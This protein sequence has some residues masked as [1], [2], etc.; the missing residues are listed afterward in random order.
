M[1]VSILQS[2]SP[3]Y[4]LLRET[5]MIGVRFLYNGN[6]SCQMAILKDLKED[7][8]NCVM[9]QLC[10]FIKN[11]RNEIEAERFKVPKMKKN[12]EETLQQNC[13]DMLTDTYGYY[14]PDQCCMMQS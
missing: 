7:A 8:E 5:F 10:F 4:E 6:T 3:S 11:I 2:E 12:V 9:T 1:I 13:R 14:D